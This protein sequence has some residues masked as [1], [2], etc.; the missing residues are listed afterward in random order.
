[1]VAGDHRVAIFAK[2]NIS[3]G[4]ELF[5]DYRYEPDKAPSWAKKPGDCATRKEDA[6]SSSS[7]RAKKLA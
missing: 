1:M 2:E 4:E 3:A 6:A 5:Y 7:R